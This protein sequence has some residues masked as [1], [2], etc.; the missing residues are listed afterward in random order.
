MTILLSF[1]IVTRVNDINK[2]LNVKLPFL[3]TLFFKYFAKYLPSNIP[4]AFI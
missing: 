2:F 3:E 4:H 1:F